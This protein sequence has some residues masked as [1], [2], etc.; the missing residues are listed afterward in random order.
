MSHPVQFFAP[1]NSFLH[2]VWP[3]GHPVCL[4]QFPAP[5]VAY[6]ESPAPS[7]VHLSFPHPVWLTLSCSHPVWFILVARTQDGLFWSLAPSVA[8]FELAA[9]SMVDLSCPHPVWLTL[10]CPHPVWSIWV[11]R[12]QCGLLSGAGIPWK[13]YWVRRS[14]IQ[15]SHTGCRDPNQAIS[16]AGILIKPYWVRGF[17][18]YWVHQAISG[19][20]IPLVLPINIKLSHTRCKI[21]PHS[22]CGTGGA[23]RT[24]GEP[25]G[26]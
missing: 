7:M 11:S 25:P 24:P 4:F 20:E 21:A 5:S 10:T 6:F 13:P 12:T 2:L 9:P 8:T 17:R 22:R 16:G 3:A 23:T 14:Q 19:A 15:S 26:F 18:P 1:K